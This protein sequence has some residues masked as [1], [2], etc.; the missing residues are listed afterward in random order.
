[1]S[2]YHPDLTEQV[3]RDPLSHNPLSA[4]LLSHSS[5]PWVHPSYGIPTHD[6]QGQFYPVCGSA[7]DQ[8]TL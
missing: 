6:I 8:S 5:F 3:K 7:T 2:K 1:M 4:M